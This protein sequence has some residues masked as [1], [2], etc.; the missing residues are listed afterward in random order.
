ME[1]GGEGG[2]RVEGGGEGGGRVGEGRVEGGE[3][4]VIIIMTN[5]F[6]I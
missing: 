1:G 3:G 6:T 2:G 5:H 4:Y